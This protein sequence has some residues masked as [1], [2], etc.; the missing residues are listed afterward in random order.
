[1]ENRNSKNTLLLVLVIILAVGV[2]VF[3]GY[4]LFNT[5]NN[6][7]NNLEQNENNN[8]QSNNNQG[9]SESNVPVTLTMSD[10][11]KLMKKYI[12]PAV[13]GGYYISELSEYFENYITILNSN[14]KTGSTCEEIYG[15]EYQS[16]SQCGQ[17]EEEPI[18]Y[19]YDEFLAQKKTLFGKTA[20][21]PTIQFVGP[22]YATYDYV[23][24]IDSFVYVGTFGG[25]DCG[26]HD[27]TELSVESFKQDGEE[28]II[29]TI[30]EEGHTNEETGE[31][32]VDITKNEY[33]FQWE[34]DHYYLA[35]IV[36]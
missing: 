29:Y 5:F 23:S 18:I 28:L 16:I 32:K 26:G 3:G 25:G 36:K 10:A 14:G 17:V 1:M 22:F 27:Y 15:K 33:R 9:N 4:F 6:K 30:R 2:G 13:C 34:D 35:E 7:T 12:N 20:T 19:P 8:N 31:Y 24:N 21:M 11:E